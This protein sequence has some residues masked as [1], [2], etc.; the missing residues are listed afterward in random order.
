MA[1]CKILKHLVDAVSITTSRA[2]LRSLSRQSESQRAA[3][4]IKIHQHL[5]PIAHLTLE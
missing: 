5:L 3:R 1:G 4:R 2:F